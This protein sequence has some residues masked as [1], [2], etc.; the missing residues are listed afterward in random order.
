[1]GCGSLTV[2]FPGDLIVKL[3]DA[4]YV[5][6]IA[7]KLFS[8]MAARKQRVRSDGRGRLVYFSFDGRFRF[9]GN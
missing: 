2:V 4:A 9:E 3:L 1:M 5:P 8:L 7:F 6:D